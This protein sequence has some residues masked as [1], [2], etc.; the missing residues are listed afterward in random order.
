MVHRAVLS[1]LWSPIWFQRG[2]N[3]LFDGDGVKGT[4]VSNKGG[5]AFYSIDKKGE[6]HYV[7]YRFPGYSDPESTFMPED[8]D[9]EYFTGVKMLHLSEATFRQI[10]TRETAL[11][12][13]HFAKENGVSISYDP[14]IRETLWN[15]KEEFFKTQK[16]I[17]SLVDV[18]LATLKEA[19]FIV[20]EQG[21]KQLIK[22]RLWVYQPSF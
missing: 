11:K 3:F 14:N 15:N 6:R 2:E 17:I 7:F 5:I 13:L 1:L 9:R 16:K 4:E 22:F 20:G 21:K 10:E 19:N 18:F 12:V 8:I